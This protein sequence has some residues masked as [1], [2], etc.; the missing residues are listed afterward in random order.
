MLDWMWMQRKDKTT[1]KTV[2]KQHRPTKQNHE[3]Q[4]PQEGATSEQN[5]TSQC[6][7]YEHN[8]VSHRPLKNKDMALNLSRRFVKSIG[9]IFED[10]FSPS[11]TI[12]K[13]TGCSFSKSKFSISDAIFTFGT[14]H[15]EPAVTLVPTHESLS[16]VSTKVNA[17]SRDAKDCSSEKCFHKSSRRCF[18]GKH[19]EQNRV[20]QSACFSRRVQRW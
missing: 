8:D 1:A 12:F 19:K 14:A 7:I 6:L 4:N 10:G 5:Y 2:G 17:D 11:T 9:V 16:M 15:A 13:E 3:Q 20:C 18:C